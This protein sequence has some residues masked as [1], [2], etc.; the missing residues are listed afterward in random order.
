MC[1]SLL[2]V[3]LDKVWSKIKLISYLVI[4]ASVNS[5]EIPRS[6]VV[7]L[8][9]LSIWLLISLLRSNL[10]IVGLGGGNPSLKLISVI[11]THLNDI[12]S[13]LDL[14]NPYIKLS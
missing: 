8:I 2:I 6:V 14:L 4:T 3:E 5:A 7:I 12:S 11:W 13:G 9:L 1:K 10:I